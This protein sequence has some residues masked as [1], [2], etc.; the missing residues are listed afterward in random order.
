MFRGIKSEGG[1][2]LNS[3]LRIKLVL[4]VLLFFVEAVSAANIGVVIEFPD[5]VYK[6]CVNVDENSDGYEVLE[7]LDGLDIDWSNPGMFG[8][9]L[10]KINGIG[11]E[12]SG[13]NCAWG[14]EY[15]AIYIADNGDW[16]YSPVGLDTP[17]DC[18]NGDFGSYGGHYCAK[19][20]DVLGFA[21][22]EYGTE[23]DF[24]SY[25]EICSDKLNLVDVKVE[26]D[27][28]EE[29]DVDK[30]GGT[31]D[32]VKPLSKIEMEIEVKSLFEDDVDM[33]VSVDG[34]L[35]DVDDSDNIKLH[36]GDS[37]TAILVF[38]IP[39][40][41]EEKDYD[42]NIDI[43]GRDENDV[44]Y[45]ENVSFKVNI[46]K[47]KHNVMIYK[48]SLENEHLV[49]DRITRLNIG[50]VNIGSN[51]E[52]VAL[53]IM[54]NELGLLIED[55]FTVD[56]EEKKEKSYL[57]NIGDE[58]KSGNY[59]LRVIARYED[60][61]DEESV[62]LSLSE[63][64]KLTSVSGSAAV[65]VGNSDERAI[66]QS[67]GAVKKGDKEEAEFVEKYG[68]TFLI[69]GGEILLIILGSIVLI[70]MSKR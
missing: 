26:V 18:W 33:D 5:S 45:Y 43:R 49:C 36:A 27:G 70:K 17:G 25:E 54:N 53:E 20:K 57:V 24:Y 62:S 39:S 21:H 60:D 8:H 28:E 56:E 32:D 61:V 7:K 3:D 44:E 64:N 4:A 37:K 23:P 40:D 31:I 1:I 68:Y 22:G 58:Q 38:K 14:S 63:C 48:V 2:K 11:E 52:D 55:S 10:C 46:D 69:V 35:G 59:V 29:D 50:I 41:I 12:V 16:A 15:W 9:A 47:E 67:S 30:N 42:L 66:V 34:V 6:R 65:D 13:T 19:D 51:D